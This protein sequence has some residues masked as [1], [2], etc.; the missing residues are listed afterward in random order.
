MTIAII[1]NI[2]SYN[3]ST[4]IEPGPVSQLMLKPLS[5]SS[6]NIQW[7]IPIQQNGIIL[8]YE[9]SITGFND[10]ILNSSMIPNVTINDLGT[11]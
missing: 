6:V 1:S 4:N 11:V 9:L 7:L 2:S 3:F 10:T 5:T 8:Y